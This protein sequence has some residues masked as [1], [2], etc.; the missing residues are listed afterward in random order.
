MDGNSRHQSKKYPQGGS[1]SSRADIFTKRRSACKRVKK[2]ISG[3]SGACIGWASYEDDHLV[4]FAIGMIMGL[5]LVGLA[6]RRKIGL[7]LVGLAIGRIM[8]LVLVGLAVA[9]VEPL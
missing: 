5:M 8:E 4:R 1:T 2:L 7:L 6:M 9:S 3:G